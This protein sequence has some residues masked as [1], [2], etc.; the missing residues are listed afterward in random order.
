MVIYEEPSEFSPK[1][2]AKSLSPKFSLAPQ[3]NNQVTNENH[4][5]NN[6]SLGKPLNQK[7]T[8]SKI[9][10]SFMGENSSTL[11]LH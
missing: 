9:N 1:F 4:N 2:G 3:Q 8:L 11:N 5:N 10:I 6:T 7:S